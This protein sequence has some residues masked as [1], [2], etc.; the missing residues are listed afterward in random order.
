MTDTVTVDK[1]CNAIETTRDKGGD[2]ALVRV[3]PDHWPTSIDDVGRPDTDNAKISPVFIHGVP[4]VPD[5]TL[6]ESTPF[7]VDA[8]SR[9]IP[10]HAQYR[11]TREIDQRYKRLTGHQFTPY[12]VL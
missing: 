1:V 12:K 11:Q 6:P 3:H 9:G 4:V 7:L 2:P 8:V 10:T 5:N